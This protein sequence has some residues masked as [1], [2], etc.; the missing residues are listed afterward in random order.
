MPSVLLTWKCNIK[1]FFMF[2]GHGVLTL[3]VSRYQF[4]ILTLNYHH[5]D[6]KYMLDF[7]ETPGLILHFYFHISCQC[8]KQTSSFQLKVGKVGTYQI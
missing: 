2:R 8:V 3:Q 1:T 5:N 7:T 6:N 4:N